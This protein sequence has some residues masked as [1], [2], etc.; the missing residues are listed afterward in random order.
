MFNFVLNFELRQTWFSRVMLSLVVYLSS[1]AACTLQPTYAQRSDRQFRE[2]DRT[3]VHSPQEM[4]R[5]LS[6]LITQ[7]RDNPLADLDPET[8]KKLN[9]LGKQFI[10]NL[11]DGQKKK[12]QEFAEKF[13][14]EKGL[15][16]PEGKALMDQFGVSP[17]IQKQLA[18]EFEE[19]SSADLKKFRELISRRGPGAG[20]GGGLPPRQAIPGLDSEKS[21]S[22]ES[23]QDSAGAGVRANRGPGEAPG[24]TK[25]S[26]NPFDANEFAKRQRREGADAVGGKPGEEPVKSRLA[27]KGQPSGAEASSGLNNLNQ[28]NTDGVKLPPRDGADDA[29]DQLVPPDGKPTGVGQPG[30]PN[31]GMLNDLAKRLKAER[32]KSVRAKGSDRQSPAKSKS[33]GNGE[34]GGASPEMPARAPGFYNQFEEQFQSW[35]KSQAIEKRLR[36]WKSSAGASQLQ[37]QKLEA[38]IK[39]GFKGLGNSLKDTLGEGTA[40]GVSKRELRD[41]IDRV[42]LKASTGGIDSQADEAESGITGSLNNAIDGFLDRMHESVNRR[43]SDRDAR[44][45]RER[46]ARRGRSGDRSED[47]RSG[48]SG[49]SAS[50]LNNRES[51]SNGDSGF[52]D[53]PRS[54][55]DDSNSGFAIL[56]NLSGVPKVDVPLL[57]S[58][59]GVFGFFGFLLFLIRNYVGE[60][61]LIPSR[62]FGKS[63]RS[64]KIRSPKDLVEAV[65]YFIVN[66]F[67]SDSRWWNAKHA[68]EMLCAG[69]P[70]YS[71]KIS[72]L[73]K[74]YVRARYTRSDAPLPNEAQ[75]SYKAI[76]Q[77][78]SKQ[79]LNHT[80]PEQSVETVVSPENRGELPTLA[81]GAKVE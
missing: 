10:E 50:D 4:F 45:K 25:D 28:P 18:Q 66:K 47:E 63:F 75:Q 60:A 2:F 53:V 59:L 11:D 51:G 16:S 20:F 6:K 14:R 19:L 37:N 65:D 21:A 58:V 56:E 49:S 8:I 15:S 34:T 26:T 64:A 78:L 76:L 44:S 48:K 55:G 3:M 42:L 79:D 46:E 72:N 39:K 77:E 57:L 71:A 81:Q 29:D 1:M 62:K 13:L 24:T 35:L 22:E 30:Q 68:Q 74:D 5:D 17:E 7:E 80:A 70:G 23:T 61:G 54:L 67:G 27:Q 69:A 43:K 38:A 41:K 12:A 31:L 33:K 32:E 9:N 52:D 73:L 36:D 40:E